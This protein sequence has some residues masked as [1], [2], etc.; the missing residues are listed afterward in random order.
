MIRH[1]LPTYRKIGKALSTIFPKLWSIF[2]TAI[3]DPSVGDITCV[4]DALDECNEQQHL[5]IEALKDFY[6]SPR[7]SSSTSRLK[8]LI[9]S[10][11]YYDIR[12]GFDGLLKASNNIELAGND[13]SESIKKEI[14]LVIKCRVKKL[15]REIQLTAKVTDYLEKR[16]LEIEHR[17]YLWL[18]L[19]WEIMRK[20]LSGT[21]Y[22]LDRTI[23]D[24]P[25]DI[26]S[27]YG[28][29]LQKC[30]QPDF[31]RT[32]LHLV[33]I[34]ARPLTLSEMGFALALSVDKETSSYTDLDLELETSSRLQETLP[35]RCGLMVSIINSRVYFIHQTV[36]EFLLGKVGTQPSARRT[37]QS[38]F[39]PV[40]SHHLMA[41]IC[42]RSITSPEIRLDQANLCNALLPK[43]DREM[44]PNAYC[45][46]HRFLSYSAIHWADH[47]LNKR[48]NEGIQTLKYVLE[49]NDSRLVKGSRGVSHGNTLHAASAGGHTEI[50]QILLEKGAEVNVK[51]G[52]YGTALIAASR[53]GHIEIVQILLEKGAEINI[54]GGHYG[55][56][57]VAA[58]LEGYTEIVQILLEK[59][60][61]INIK[62]G[63]YGTAL[64]AASLEGYTE[65]VQILLEKGAEINIKGGYYGTALEAASFKGH[66]EVVRI[67]LEKGAKVNTQTQSRAYGTALGVASLSGHI[68]IVQILLE[69]GAEVNAKGGR[70]STALGAA[71][72]GGC[73]EIVQILLE[74]GAEVNAEGGRYGTA[75]EAALRQGHIEIVQILLEKKIQGIVRRSFN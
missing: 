51:G 31:A 23:D 62:G 17:T 41:K 25:D 38:S 46:A 4:L 50:V 37:W 15:G 33:L 66:T 64:V 54:K 71:S 48:N 32:V 61:E 42:L 53:Q 18:H 1:A 67:L 6:L 29:L 27:S 16:L 73:I 19:V 58:S 56:A 30:P 69:K 74:K 63:H 60:A 57:L 59:G 5:L 3:T 28:V 40:E 21:K 20:N 52:H 22:E 8:F 55:T 49:T 13:E 39:D 68:E 43:H 2:I 35:S 10:R 45:Q 75:L 72:F 12:R 47:F 44:R 34:A 11:P 7:N 24:L 65:I 9:T 70:Y 36:K 14:D 26:Q